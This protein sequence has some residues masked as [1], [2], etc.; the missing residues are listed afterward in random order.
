LGEREVQ[1]G[2]QAPRSNGA[3]A[4]GRPEPGTD[5]GTHRSGDGREVSA[6]V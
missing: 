2:E 4:A 1:A 3:R 5:P 6:T